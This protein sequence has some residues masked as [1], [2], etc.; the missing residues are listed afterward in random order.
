MISRLLNE[1][2]GHVGFRI[3][4]KGDC[5]RLSDII[6]ES[7]DEDISY[8]TLRRLYGLAG[9]VQPR[10]GTLDVLSRLLGYRNY[11]DFTLSSPINARWHEKEAVL[12]M[13]SHGQIEGSMRRI[14]EIENDSLR[15]DVALQLAREWAI[16]GEFRRMVNLLE[17]PSL[18]VRPMPYSG[19]LHFAHSL[20]LLFRSLEVDPSLVLKSLRFQQTVY[21]LFVDYTSL[22][23]YYGAWNDWYLGGHIE[24]DDALS[25]FNR[26]LAMLR[27]RLNGEDMGMLELTGVDFALLHPIL[28]SRVFSVL[29]MTEYPLDLDGLWSFVHGGRTP[30]GP[31]A[32]SAVHEIQFIAILCGDLELIDWLLD[33]V[34]IQT[35]RLQHH[36]Y[37]DLQLHRLVE[38]VQILLSG[39]KSQCRSA[40]EKVDLQLVNLSMKEMVSLLYQVVFLCSGRNRPE[41]WARYDSLAAKVGV[42]I[43]DRSFVEQYTQ[44]D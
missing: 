8:N 38:A 17:L 28:R 30:E 21:T 20:G 4:S 9:S 36:E 1:V 23:G 13:V 22:N 25:L 42:S 44:K 40:L 19:Q 26:C 3:R 11:S 24:I 5:L 34:E 7:N 15:L 43:F 35:N 31:V 41:H 33:G 32:I 12:L 14:E 37:H 29:R 16:G 27:R 2:E 18:D 39:R 6:L 10:T